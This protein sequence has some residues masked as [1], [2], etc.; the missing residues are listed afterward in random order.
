MSANIT[1]QEYEE[2]LARARA[3][4][5]FQPPATP[6]LI[7][8]PIKHGTPRR[9]WNKT[10]EAFSRLLDIRLR[11]GEI[12]EWWFEA[13]TFKLGR[14]CRY[15]PDFAA[16]HADGSLHL[17][18]VKGSFCRDDAKAKFRAAATMFP[19]FGWWWAQL[20]KGEWSIEQE[21][22]TLR[23]ARQGAQGGL[24]FVQHR[25]EI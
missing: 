19:F 10:E 22:G 8:R 24:K 1:E 3:N 2:M 20:K 11:A 9:H 14:D 17:H 21:P 25:P 7:V 15:T 16:I 4:R 13:L 6:T 12:R 18:E 23:P 5:T